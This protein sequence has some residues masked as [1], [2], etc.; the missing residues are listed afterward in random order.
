L[1]ALHPTLPALIC[2]VGGDLLL[3]I[4][5]LAFNRESRPW[6]APGLA[7]GWLAFQTLRWL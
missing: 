7:L 1:L 5:S 4:L 2:L 6:A 3:R